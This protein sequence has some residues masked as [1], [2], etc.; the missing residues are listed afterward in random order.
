MDTA[1]ELARA[2][3]DFDAGDRYLDEKLSKRA[4]QGMCEGEFTDILILAA[5]TYYGW[6]TLHIRP[7]RKINGGWVTPVSGDGVGFP[8]LQ[9]VRRSTKQQVVAELKVGRNKKTDA[10]DAWLSDFEACGTP[11]YT[12]RPTDL[13]EIKQVLRHGMEAE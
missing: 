6:R 9:L 3:P 10:Q 7:A 8:D 5:R 13:E 4:I 1:I 12:W 2:E 11:A